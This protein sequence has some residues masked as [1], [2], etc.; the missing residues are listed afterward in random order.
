MYRFRT[1]ENLLGKFKEL[2]NQEIYFASPEELNDPMEGYKDFFWKGDE[3]VWNNFLI[4]YVKS[5]EYIFRLF[6]VLQPEKKITEKD[7]LICR[8]L[9]PT[10]TPFYSKLITDILALIFQKA[11]I[12]KFG[13]SMA[14]RKT[15]V[16]RSEL[17]YQLQMIHLHILNAISEV[18]YINGL[19][20]KRQLYSDLSSQE[21]LLNMHGDFGSLFNKLEEERGS[22]V[23][24]VMFSVINNFME[25]L[26]LQRKQEMF[27]HEEY[28]NGFFLISEFPN[29][30]LNKLES[31]V[32]PL[33]YSASFLSHCDNSAI[34]GHYGYN[35]RGVCMKFKILEDANKLILNLETEY[36]YSSDSGSLIGMRPQTFKQVQYHNKH[37]EIDYFRSLARFT[38]NELNSWWYKDKSG[39][40]SECAMH[41]ESEDLENKWRDEYWRNF[42]SSFSI[43]LSEWEYENEYRLVIHGNLHDYSEKKNRKLKYDFNDLEEIIFGIKTDNADKVQIINI[44]KEKCKKYNRDNF[45]FYQAYYSKDTGKIEKQKIEFFDFD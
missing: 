31:E 5:L 10:I 18:Y 9:I 8:E 29:K 23:T 7:I 14:S 19:T 26:L 3:I 35:H 22:S 41:F 21:K 16:R 4:N 40:I 11:H 38:K 2:E 20:Q 37:T 12:R 33:W 17:S 30:F 45:D 1:V 25:S 36:G 43:K 15:T 32:F 13:T 24:N 34:W 44:I 28:S 39:N 6:T 27:T 42:E